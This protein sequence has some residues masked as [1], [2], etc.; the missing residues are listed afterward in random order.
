MTKGKVYLVGAGPGDRGLISI[1]GMECI[2]KAD[3]I[4]YDRLVNT[5]LL[6]NRKEESELIYV[7]KKSSFH[8]VPQNQINEIISSKAMDGKMVV[9]LKGGD[10]YVFGRGGEEAEVLYDKGIDFEVVPGITSA[11]GGLCYAGIPVTHRD[12][13]ASFHVITGHS[14]KG[15][16]PNINWEALAHENGTIVFLMSIGNIEEVVDKLISNGRSKDTTVAF[17]SWASTPI[18]KKIITTLDKAVDVVKTKTIQAPALF[19]VGDVC[20]L[21]SKLDFFEKKAMFGKTVLLTRNKKKNSEVKAKIEEMGGR[22]ID[23]P[24]ISIKTD[25][26]KADLLIESFERNNSIVFTSH[27][28][29][30]SFFELLKNKKYD[31]RKLAGFRIFSIGR[32][33]SDELENYG[34]YDYIQS[35]EYTGEGLANTM[36]KYSKEN[37]LKLDV[38][39]PCSSIAKDSIE[40]ILSKEQNSIERVEVYKNEIEFGYRDLLIEEL[41]SKMV[42]YITFTSSST[43]DN[44]IRLIGEENK[45]VLDNVKIISIGKITSETIR[46]YGLNIYKEAEKPSIDSMID[47]MLD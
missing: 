14:K 40:K 33:T 2:K 36:N 39:Y 46:S 43:V 1:K 19:V 29:V 16:A 37:N 5:Q 10:P 32:Y 30:R 24:T 34:F 26:S 13:A 31:I 12:Y 45:S 28:S 47:C 11:I 35:N 38:V 9:R 3:V 41:E 7:G 22:V 4:I 44:T 15:D 18:Q 25:Y 20:S 42:D 8:S 23:I 21:S 6:E 27:N 17:V